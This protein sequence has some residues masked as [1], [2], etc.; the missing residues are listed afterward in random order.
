MPDSESSKFT[1][2][3]SVGKDW[4]HYRRYLADMEQLVYTRQSTLDQGNGRGER[5]IEVNNGSGLSFTITPDR[6]MDIV[7][8]SFKGIPLAFRTPCGY[9]RGGKFEAEN[10]GWLRSWPG[11]LLTTCGLRHVGPPV[12]DTGDTLDPVRGLHGRISTQSAE[13]VSVYRGWNN[14]IY[15]ITIS[16]IIREAM[17]F[18]ENLRLRRTIRTAFGTNTISLDD[19]IENLGHRPEPFQILYHCNFGYP[20][21][22]PESYLEAEEHEVIPRDK[23]SEDELA[24]WKIMPESQET[25]TEQCFLHKIPDDAE[26]WSQMKVV[27]SHNKLQIIVSYDTKNLPNM[28]QWKLPEY[29]RYVLGLEPTNIDFTD[30]V[31]NTISAGNKISTHIKLS[32]GF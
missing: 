24:N 16:G 14:G 8:A 10:F 2:C 9:V 1:D 32:F 15:E 17:M 22:M 28:L 5:I 3:N 25:I 21:I 13:D 11:G 19:E 6:G 4:Q 23:P 30:K 20:A 29:G 26:G 31:I 7:D 12:T 18:G 27:N